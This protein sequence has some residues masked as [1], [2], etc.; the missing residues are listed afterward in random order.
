MAYTTI[1]DS[2]LY[3]RV[4]TYSGSSSD[5]NAVTWNETHENMQP[6]WLWLKNRTDAQ[7]HWLAD[8][9]RGTGK[10]L[11]SNSTNAESS[12]GAS[13][14]A[15]FD[16]NGFT[17]NNSARTNRNTM[18]GWGWKA[19]G[20]ASSNSNGTITSSVSANTTAGF[21]IVSYTSNGSASQTVGHGLA[22]V[23]QVII[24]KNRTNG[25]STYGNWIVYHHS[26]AT[27]NDKKILLNSTSASS[28]TNEWG[29]TDPTSSVY[30]VHTGGDGATNHSTDQIVSYCF[31]EKKGYSKFGIYEGASSADGSYI[32]LG[33]K[34]AWFLA[35]AI[36]RSENW[37]LFDNKRLGYNVDNNQLYPDTSGAE[38]TTDW[39]DFLSNGVKYRY[40]SIG[41]NGSGEQYIYMAFAES[42][43][44]NS[45]GV[46]N[47]AR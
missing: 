30:S 7:E 11:E 9:V 26:L 38:G 20:S 27:A 8:S 18:V 43:F 10:F 29:D 36:G 37:Y 21:S 17:L 19:G 35:K 34:P 40:N 6:D 22:S 31:A 33:F 44:V 39:I 41:L 25:T 16:T 45:K 24:S 1:D 13:G 3:F 14:L 47:N 32:H 4:K 15:S 28:T 46:P 2:S 12:D 42:P 23:P 5:G